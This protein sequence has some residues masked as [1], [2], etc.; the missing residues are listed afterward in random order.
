M[1]SA[2]QWADNVAGR[3]L[4]RLPVTVTKAYGGCAPPRREDIAAQV[5]PF[6][7]SLVALEAKLEQQRQRL[8][9]LAERDWQGGSLVAG[10]HQAGRFQ[11]EF[12]PAEWDIYRLT[13][14]G[15]SNG[16]LS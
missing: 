1:L 4:A 10:P 11:R 12:D 16:N 15:S 2:E 14:K 9:D 7:V 13:R 3:V 5:L 8:A 6:C